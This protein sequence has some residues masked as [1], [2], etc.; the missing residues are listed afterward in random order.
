MSLKKPSGLEGEYFAREEFFRQQAIEAE[1]HEEMEEEEKAR[2]KDLHF[3][4]CPTCG[5]GLVTIDFKGVQIDR[6]TGCEGVWLDQGELDTIAEM[7]PTKLE[8]LFNVF[9]PVDWKPDL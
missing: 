7:E 4:K 2:Q 9:K 5:L 8:K 6:C 1:K 3:M